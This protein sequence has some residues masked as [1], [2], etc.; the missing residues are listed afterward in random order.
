[1]RPISSGIV[2]RWA[3]QS[4]GCVSRV[5]DAKAAFFAENRQLIRPCLGAIVSPTD[6]DFAWTLENPGSAKHCAGWHAPCHKSEQRNEVV[7]WR[8]RTPGEAGPAARILAYLAERPTAADSPRG[9]AEWWLGGVVDIAAVEV[10]LEALAAEDLVRAETLAD[11]TRV[12]SA[13]PALLTSRQ[14]DRDCG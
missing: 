2:A 3:S 6:L 1:M 11:G 9:I 5:P 14:H 13:G 12:W 4:H 10:A 8:M 7:C